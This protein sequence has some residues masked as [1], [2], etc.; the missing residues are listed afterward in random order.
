LGS[1]SASQAIRADPCTNCEVR[2]LG[3]YNIYVHSGSNAEIDQTQVNC[4]VYSGVGFLVHDNTM[5][6]AGWCLYMDDGNAQNQAVYNNNIYNIDHGIAV[7][8]GGNNATAGPW[9]FYGNHVHDYANWDTSSNSYHHDGIHCYTV[10]S[11]SAAQKYGAQWQDMWIYNNRF[12]GNIGGNVTGHLFL[13]PGVQTDGTATPCMNASSAI[14]IFGNLFIGETANGTL[15]LGAGGSWDT[16]T[17]PVDFYNNTSFGSEATDSRQVVFE[18]VSTVNAINNIVGGANQLWSGVSFNNTDYNGYITCSTS[19]SYNCW[20]TSG[21]TNNFSTWTSYCKCDLHSVNDQQN[22][23]S[24]NQTTGALLSGSN[25]I[26]VGK[27]LTSAVSAWPTAQQNALFTDQNGNARGSG[28]WDM[29]GLSSSS[30]N[31]SAPNPPTNLAAT[32][33]PD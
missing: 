6:D 8:P 1:Q 13:E 31:A 12:D 29:G 3:I 15:D 19:A 16:L 2:N 25:M 26:G 21:M 7:T 32:A 17:T 30:T 11:G 10:T 4:M 14:H 27:N 24:V 33:T 28:S 22:T 20:P 23:G 9:Y 18:N 5:H